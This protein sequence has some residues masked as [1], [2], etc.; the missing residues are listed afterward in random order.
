MKPPTIKTK[1]KA[2]H[3]S[4][5]VDSPALLCRYGGDAHTLARPLAFARAIA[6]APSAHRALRAASRGRGRR[7]RRLSKRV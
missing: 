3:Q 7:P 2:S 1:Q 5:V 4:A 6:R